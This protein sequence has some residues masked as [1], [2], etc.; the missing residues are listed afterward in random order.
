MAFTMCYLENVRGHYRQDQQWKITSDSIHV[1]QQF[2]FIKGWQRGIPNYHS[3]ASLARSCF[4]E[5]KQ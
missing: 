3:E 5:S 2:G 4:S 1:I